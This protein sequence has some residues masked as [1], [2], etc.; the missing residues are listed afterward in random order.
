VCPNVNKPSI[1]EKAKLAIPWFQLR[2]KKDA[3]HNKRRKN[4][5]TM[6]WADILEKRR[7]VILSQQHALLALTSTNGASVPSSLMGLMTSIICCNN[8][9]LHQDV[10]VNLSSQSTKPQIPIAIHSPMPHLTLQTGVSKEEQDCPGL[11]CM[12]YSGALLNTAKFNYMEAVIWQ[13]PQILKAIYLPDN[14]A[15]IVLSGIVTSPD[16]ALS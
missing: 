4:L 9:M 6:N 1:K 2:C 11:R 16:E 13:Y 15:A 8:V 5:N 7:E 14:Y 12:L 3:C 10:I